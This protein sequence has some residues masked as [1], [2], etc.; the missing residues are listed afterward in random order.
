MKWLHAATKLLRQCAAAI[1]LRG[2]KNGF[3]RIFSKT[4]ENNAICFVTNVKKN[5]ATGCDIVDQ[6]AKKCRKKLKKINVL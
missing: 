3:Q 4:H 1:I 6:K 5:Q 2:K